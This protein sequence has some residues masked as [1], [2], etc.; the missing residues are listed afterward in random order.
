MNSDVE[1]FEQELDHFRRDVESGLQSLYAYLAIHNLAARKKSRH[2][3]MRK[4]PLLWNTLLWALQNSQ[5]I[6]LGRIFGKKTKH[7]A[8]AL[9]DF[10]RTHADIFSRQELASRKAPDPNHPPTWLKNYI[11]GAYIPQATD[12][13]RLARYLE[14]R[15]QTYLHKCR[16]IRSKIIAHNVII[17]PQQISDIFSRTKY[18]EIIDIFSFLQ[19]LYDCLWNLF[20]NGRKPILKQQRRSIRRLLES[21][22]QPWLARN[23]QATIVQDVKQ[24]FVMLE[25][26][27]S[28]ELSKLSRY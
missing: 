2:E 7:N 25:G 8:Y 1:I 21:E 6:L 10:A 24:L 22:K 11:A 14:K 4:T 23:V 15:S 5:F 3:L 16:D 9:L 13:D 12:F 17:D 28:I 27:S 18:G 19:K 26:G 20:E